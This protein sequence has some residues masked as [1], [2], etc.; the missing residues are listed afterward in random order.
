VLCSGPVG[1]RKTCAEAHPTSIM[2]TG[3]YYEEVGDLSQAHSWVL[4]RGY[5]DF[6]EFRTCEVGEKFRHEIDMKTGAKQAYLLEIPK[7]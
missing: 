2:D 5:A 7:T 3:V 4:D 1:Q 6:R